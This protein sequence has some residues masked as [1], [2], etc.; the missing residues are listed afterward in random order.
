MN[1]KYI[2]IHL[3]VCWTVPLFFVLF[4]ETTV[5]F[6]W[7]GRL[8]PS[9]A[10][11]ALQS[12][13]SRASLARQEHDV[14]NRPNLSEVCWSKNLVRQ[15]KHEINQAN[16]CVSYRRVSCLHINFCLIIVW[17]SYKNTN[18]DIGTI[19]R[20]KFI[21]DLSIPDSYEKIKKYGSI[22]IKKKINFKYHDV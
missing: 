12:S 6:D 16:N 3:K 13:Y 18:P 20:W 5:L 22:N 17:G 19:N 10:F 1:Y 8:K 7:T 9:L 14:W 2:R 21:F 4:S 15:F 11:V